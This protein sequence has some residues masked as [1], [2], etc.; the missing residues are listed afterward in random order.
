MRQ[1]IFLKLFTTFDEIRFLILYFIAGEEENPLY[2]KWSSWFGDSP[3]APE[4]FFLKI[5]LYS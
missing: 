5:I 4:K 2:A 3:S 1:G